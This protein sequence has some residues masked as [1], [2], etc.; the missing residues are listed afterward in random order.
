RRGDRRLE[1]VPVKT[2]RL[3]VHDPNHVAFRKGRAVLEMPAAARAGAREARPNHSVK[4]ERLDRVVLL[5]PAAEQGDKDSGDR[6]PTSHLTASAGRTGGAVTVNE[7]CPWS[8]RNIPQRPSANRPAQILPVRSAAASAISPSPSGTRLP[9]S[10]PPGAICRKGSQARPRLI[11]TPF[12]AAETVPRPLPR[13]T[14]GGRYVRLA[15]TPDA[16]GTMR[17]T[18]SHDRDVTSGTSTAPSETRAN[19]IDARLPSTRTGEGTATG[20]AT[21]P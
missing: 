3:T 1:L 14:M 7:V 18:P 17:W 11:R 16:R 9:S 2:N 4:V 13:E 15:K 6:E 20:G 5:A 21:R 10:S 19:G 8:G 12:A